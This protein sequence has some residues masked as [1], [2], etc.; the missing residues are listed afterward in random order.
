MFSHE[1][2]SIAKESRLH[3]LNMTVQSAQ[4]IIF[5]LEENDRQNLGDV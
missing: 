1:V 3:L 4:Y 5:I 2:L